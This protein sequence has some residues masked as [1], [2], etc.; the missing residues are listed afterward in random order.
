MVAIFAAGRSSC[1]QI[2][3]YLYRIRPTVSR[4][5]CCCSFLSAA[6]VDVL[7]S[8]EPGVQN[9]R[10]VIVMSLGEENRFSFFV[11]HR[12]GSGWFSNPE[13]TTTATDSHRVRNTTNNGTS[14]SLELPLFLD[15]QLLTRELRCRS[16]VGKPK[17]QMSSGV[18]R[19]R[20]RSWFMGL[21]I[22]H[23]Q[24]L[25]S[26]A[27]HSKI[28]GTSIF[29]KGPFWRCKVRKSSTHLRVLGNKSKCCICASL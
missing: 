3:T 22:W 24:G 17:T 27:S 11:F 15:K 8:L 12:A 18:Q 28:Y 16:D 5:K 25:G 29:S 9:W 14:T 2:F 23:C 19:V 6:F 26:S 1:D 20:L 13:V 21:D 7:Q 4:R 10:P